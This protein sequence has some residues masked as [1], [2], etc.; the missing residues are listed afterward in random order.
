[1]D[2]KIEKYLYLLF[3]FF[4]LL[5]SFGL[6]YRY[7]AAEQLGISINVLNYGSFYPEIVNEKFYPASSYFPGFSLI[8]YLLRFLIPDYFLMEFISIISVLSIFFFFYI[9]K[10]ISEETFKNKI[11]YDNFWLIAIILCLWPCR[12][13]LWYAAQLKSDILAFGLIFFSIY[14][15]KPYLQKGK[16][17]FDLVFFLISILILLFAA[18]IKQQSVFVLFALFF[19]SILNRNLYFKIFSFISLL[20]ILLLYFYFYNYENLWFFNVSRY[21]VDRFLTIN[22]FIKI[23]YI[24]FIRIF[25]FLLF[26]FACFYEKLVLINFKSKVNFLKK[27]LKKNFWIYLCISFSATGTISFFKIGSNSANF[28][29][30][31]IVFTIFIFYFLSDFKKKILNFLI[32]ALL[33]ME[34]PNIYVSFKHYI[35]SKHMQNSILNN[36]KG[37]NLKI[38]TSD[39]VMFSSFLISKNNH[40]YSFDTAQSLYRINNQ[41]D[42]KSFFLDKN[43]L[44]HYDFI[45]L[46]KD[47]INHVNL[48]NFEILSSEFF[49]NIYKKKIE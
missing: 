36:I 27:N 19:Y 43:D 1:M 3:G 20:G 31:I 24:A 18:S 44:L 40:I 33:F 46:S 2:K 42:F 14:L 47:K 32:I 49:G 8:I 9:S 37:K 5:E 25:L 12:Y 11:N 35:D 41:G 48:K 29:L 21:S 39:N 30:S 15:I 6:F 23:N 13:W 22:E 10:K 17:K 16:I 38:L 7:P 4:L 45:I 34:I 26:V 28:E